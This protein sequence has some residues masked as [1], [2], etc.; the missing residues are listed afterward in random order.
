MTRWWITYYKM[1]RD[2]KDLGISDEAFDEFCNAIES[3]CDDYGINYMGLY[4]AKPEYYDAFAAYGIETAILTDSSSIPL[5]TLALDDNDYVGE[6]EPIT[7]A[8]VDSA[9]SEYSIERI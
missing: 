3:T 5:V 7:Q 4:V 1:V 2:I 6:F 9:L 8:D